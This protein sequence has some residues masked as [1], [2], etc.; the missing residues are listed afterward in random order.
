METVSGL[1]LPGH[2]GCL[3]RPIKPATELRADTSCEHGR[4]S[5]TWNCRVMGSR[6]RGD[7]S[8]SP[9]APPTRALP[10]CSGVEE[11][12]AAIRQGRWSSPDPPALPPSSVEERLLPG[13]RPAWWC[14][15]R[16][17]TVSLLPFPPGPFSLL[18]GCF[19]VH[20]KQA[21]ASLI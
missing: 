17:P 15:S 13:P 7:P 12:E 21:Q 6:P 1:R 9:R 4:Y 16:P 19:P 10:N 14:V 5:N 11:R 3:F 18:T 8:P 2:P 20:L